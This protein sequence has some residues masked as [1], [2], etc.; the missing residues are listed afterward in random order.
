MK[1]LLFLVPVVGLAGL[2]FA[3]FLKSYVI[4]QDPGTDR[5]REIADAI[6]E[7]ARA[8]LASEYRILVIF[9]AVLFVV[10]GVGTRNWVTAVC[11]LT[12][13]LFSTAAGYLGMSAAIRANCRTA[14]AA[15]TQG[16]K[17][18][19]A[20]AFSGG[21]VMGMAVV[22][23][24]L[25]G[26]GTLYII[27]GDVSV[28]SGFS[29]GASSIA[30]FAR[31]GGGIYTKAADVGA[32]LV[33]KVE[34]GIPEDD[35]RNP[36]VIADNVGDNVGDVAGMGADLFESYV[37]SLISALTLG[38]VFYQEAGVLFPLLLSAAGI[39]ASMIGSA[40]VKAIG[41]ADPH[42]A[43]KTGEYSATALVVIS[44]LVLS[45]TFFGNFLAAFTVI[46][47]LFV[48]VLIGAITEVYTSGDYR[49]VKKIAKQSETGSATTI[50]SG[51]A[52]GMQSTAVPILLVS[53][54]IL[55]ANRLMGLY[56]IALAAV[57]MLST[58]GI[59]VAI[60]AYGPIADN[61]GGIAEMSELDDS[62][63]EITDKLDS[64]GNTTAAIGKGFAIGS[65][66]LTAL[67]LFVSYAEAVQL[68]TIDILNA[69]VIVGLFMGG[70]LTFLFSAMTMESVSKA[71]HEM[72]EE[73]RRQF[74]EDAGILKGTSRPDYA[75]CVSISTNAALKEMFLPGLMA[76][77]APIAVGLILGPD[78]LGG[79]LTGALLTG[80]LMAIFMSNSGGAW[81]NA[82]KYIEEG[83]HGG[84]GST[85]H[86]A[87]VVGDTVGDPFKDTSGPSIN[88][89][90]KLMTIVSLV[91]A[92]LFLQFG[93]LI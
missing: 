40:L 31:V 33:G 13:S 91:F 79:L 27:T 73:V 36:A 15:R 2:L 76:V 43:L 48:G 81:D 53:A 28:L 47:G 16:M 89:L 1:E 21:S 75:S 67:A 17:R 84:K 7:G 23:L 5:M 64:V 87:A 19:L 60:D 42:K 82:K 4:K 3:I 29:L 83:N 37:G 12:G 44:A 85:A 80:V 93:G 77:L 69:H 49:F 11:F 90:I 6:A 52:V 59:T 78:A 32:D 72:I 57:G 25:L 86:K 39:I 58:T 20:L 38:I 51:L 74:H 56:G 54:G 8:F 66:A 46:A 50:I 18:A 65:A 30:L 24:G 71:A 35:P 41:N 88:I 26:V 61:A 45:R 68:K 34:A 9:V 14:N 70:M 92:P 22:G 62:V 63:R 10:I 55:V